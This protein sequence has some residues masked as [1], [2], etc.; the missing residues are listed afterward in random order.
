M[1][2]RWKVDGGE[3]NL[4]QGSFGNIHETSSISQWNDYYKAQQRC[5]VRTIVFC[6]S[7]SRC[8]ST[9]LYAVHVITLWPLG[10]VFMLRRKCVYRIDFASAWKLYLIG[11]LF[12]KKEGDFGAISAPHPS[13]KSRVTYRKGVYTITNSFSCPAGKRLSGIGKHILRLTSNYSAPNRDTFSFGTKTISDR[14]SVHTSERLWR[15]HSCNSAKIC[16]QRKVG[17]RKR[18]RRAICVNIAL[19][20][21]AYRL[22]DLKIKRD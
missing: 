2:V 4:R 12:R 8:A 11:L 10:L 3:T 18:S 19:Y 16:V 14:A 7:F 20:L 9:T 5:I 17:K 6:R 22:K 15:R 21:R 1:N 13:L